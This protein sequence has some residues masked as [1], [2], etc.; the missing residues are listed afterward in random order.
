[1]FILGAVL[2]VYCKYINHQFF[3]ST[4]SIMNFLN[5]VLKFD[6][7][8]LL[9]LIFI[10]IPTFGEHLDLKKAVLFQSYINIKKS[11]VDVKMFF[12]PSRTLRLTQFCL[13]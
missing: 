6:L 5:I 4:H 1:M 11:A 12:F 7:Y 2:A 13:D 9:F 3:I 8:H 10:M